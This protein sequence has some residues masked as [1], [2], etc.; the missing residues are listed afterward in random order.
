MEQRIPTAL[1]TGCGRRRLGHAIAKHLAQLGFNIAAHFNSSRSAA[2]RNV[3]EYQALGANATAIQADVTNEDQVKQLVADVQT[4][5]GG[6]DVLVTTASIWRAIP[7]EDVTA[8]NVLDSFRVNTLG[9]FLCCQQV[10]LAMVK[11]PSGGNIVTIGDALVDH[12]YLDHAAYFT[13]KGSIE[14][15]TKSFAVELG[16]RNPKVRVNGIAPGPVMFPDHLTS[17]D[18]TRV[19]ASTL[20]KIANDPQAVAR[21][22]EFLVQCS[23]ITGE[24]ITLDSGRNVDREQQSRQRIDLP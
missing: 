7:L 6:I 24:M 1:I 21:T 8:E 10:G 11:Q 17:E 3:D 16:N 15:L 19:T 20:S 9:T 22:V 13:A 23:M 12:P 5:F 2:L 4:T 14:S 18:R